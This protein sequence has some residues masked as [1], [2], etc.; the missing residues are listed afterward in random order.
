MTG[1]P[2]TNP[3]DPTETPLWARDA[4]EIADGVRAGRLSAAAVV[5]AHLERI[6]Q[7]DQPLRSFVE[8]DA[9]GAM[10]RAAEVDKA[11]VAGRDPG[12][13]AGVPL[14]VKDLEDAAGLP[15]RRGSALFQRVAP[16]D[17]DSIQVARLR[18]AGAVVVGKTAT[19]EFGS[20]AFTWSPAFGTTKRRSLLPGRSLPVAFLGWMP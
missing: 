5:E 11:V 2:R 15:T 18:A 16:V 6:A 1:G 14:G 9:E 3:R 13:L 20:L 4:W 17:Q 8:I 7:L 19:P 12:P 10:C